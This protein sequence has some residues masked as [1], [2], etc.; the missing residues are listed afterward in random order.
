MDIGVLM[1]AEIKTK[2]TKV[3]VDLDYID[4]KEEYF[5]YISVNFDLTEDVGCFFAESY[6]IFLLDEIKSLFQGVL[7]MDSKEIRI[8]GAAI[9]IDLPSESAKH[10]AADVLGLVKRIERKFDAKAA[11]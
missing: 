1:S 4:P 8:D 10:M 9:L 7:G 5:G 11:E 6:D 3:S 2:Y